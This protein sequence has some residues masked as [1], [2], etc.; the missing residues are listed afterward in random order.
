MTTIPEVAASFLVITYA[1]PNPASLGGGV[2]WQGGLRVLL[3]PYL[4]PLIF[5]GMQR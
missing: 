2:R 5:G 4:Q 3:Y 1:R